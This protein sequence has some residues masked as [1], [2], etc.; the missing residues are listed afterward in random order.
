MTLTAIPTGPA[1]TGTAAFVTYT[2]NMLPAVGA[3]DLGN[4]EGAAIPP[5]ATGEVVVVPV[6]ANVDAA[7]GELYAMHIQLQFDDSVVSFESLTRGSDWNGGLFAHHVVAAGIV[8]FG[9]IGGTPAVPSTSATLRRRRSGHGATLLQIA[10]VSLRVADT[11]GTSSL[12]ANVVTLATANGTDIASAA[13]PAGN[14]PFIVGGSTA[15]SAWTPVAYVSPEA[16][17]SAWDL[18]GDVDGNCMVDVRDV[19]FL[20]QYLDATPEAQGAA[21]LTAPQRMYMDAN[22][23][24]LVNSQDLSALFFAQFALVPLVSSVGVAPV[25]QANECFLHVSAEVV[26]RSGTYGVQSVSGSVYR[27]VF[28]VE[29][30]VGGL[31]TGLTSTTLYPGFTIGSST[32][33]TALWE[34]EQDSS[35]GR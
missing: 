29:S 25:N 13:S 16:N 30:T 15:P 5:T 17:C 8:E 1:G 12:V 33:T 10:V 21:S 14:V 27:I 23:D 7:D 19:V 31:D 32:S 2:P 34:A 9:G 4:Q 3:L 22:M 35:T 11:P 6:F 24:G 20:Q 26:V 28:V 18:T